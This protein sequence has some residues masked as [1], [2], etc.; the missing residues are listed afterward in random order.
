MNSIPQKVTDRLSAG[1][2]RFQPILDGAKKRGDNETDTAKIIIEM[3]SDI[4]GYDKFTE[5]KS[6][7][8]VRGGTF[9]GFAIKLNDQD[10]PCFLVEA[11]AVN[12]DLKDNHTNQALAYSARE[13]STCAV[14]GSAETAEQPPIA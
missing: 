14:E 9:C 3:L 4:F 12:I 13:D 10:K 7:H 5:I 11:K 1:I 6:E 2:K 8:A